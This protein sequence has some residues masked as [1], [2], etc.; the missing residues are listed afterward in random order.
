MLSLKVIGLEKVIG[1]LGK[2]TTQKPLKSSVKR[3][4]LKLEGLVK[5]ATVVL[6]G[7]LRSRIESEVQPLWGRVFSI[8]DYVADVE[9]GMPSGTMEARHMEGATKVL[10]LGMFGYGLEQLNEKLKEE[11]DDL[12]KGIELE[13]ERR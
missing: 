1:K 2:D 7:Y 10:G 9:Y 4:T 3:I 13:F 11:E 6:T 12:A 5:K 8:V